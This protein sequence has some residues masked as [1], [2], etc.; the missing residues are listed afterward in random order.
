MRSKASYKGH[1]IH[2]ALIPFPFA[3]LYG[4]FL[5]DV[6][7]R[8]AERPSWWTTGAYLS[9]VGVIAALIAAVPG[10]I[11][12]FN[13]VPPKSSG[14]RRATKHMLANLTVVV[15]F[16]AALVVRSHPEAMPDVTVLTLEGIAVVLLTVGGWMGGV[17][18]SRNQISVDHRYAQAGKWKEAKIEH[19]SNQPVVVAKS[20]ELKPDQMK[21]LRVNG[22]RLV[23]ARTQDGYVAFDDRC[24]HRGGSLAGGVMI[25]GV[26]QC[27]WHGSQFDC[28]SG[29]I[30]AGPA[31]EPIATYSV[32][33]R[34]GKILLTLGA[35]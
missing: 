33:E 22:R 11:D 4:A 29:A 20:D 18:V 24:P 30:K 16:A 23:L 35:E 28:R 6:A 3:F 27:P 1:P 31:V 25:A 19:K 15:L 34:E 9:L 26:V 14:K 13:T 10:F 12:Y 21:L 17:L 2:P 8:I 5:F 32:S 7:G